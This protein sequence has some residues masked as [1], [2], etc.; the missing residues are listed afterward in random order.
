MPKQ[1]MAQT[2][3]FQD[4]ESP[5]VPRLPQDVQIELLRQMVKWMQA[6]ALAINKEAHD[7]QD[8]R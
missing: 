8:H 2:E 3:L 4:V 7:E 6:V 5:P 1:P